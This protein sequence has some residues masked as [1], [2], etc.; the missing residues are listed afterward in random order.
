[1]NKNVLVCPLDWGIGHAT[2][3]VPVIKELIASGAHVFIAADNQPLAFLMKEFPDL[4]FVKF[5]G[6]NIYYPENGSMIIKM[7]LSLPKFLKE[8]KKENRLLAQIIA[9]KNI[10]V[11][12]SD[13]R[14][15]LWNKSVK[16]VFITHQLAIKCPKHFIFLEYLLFRINRRYI[17][18]YN[19]CWVPDFDTY[20]NLSGDLSHKRAKNRN[21][22]FIGPLSR[23]SVYK[24]KSANDVQENDIIAILS[25]PEP[26]RTIFENILTKQLLELPDLKA[27]IV[28]GKP[29]AEYSF[30]K[31]GN[32]E[33]YP[34]LDTKT[35][36]EKIYSAK[37]VICRSGY[38][39]I[40]DLAVIGAKAVLVPTPGQTEQE[41]LAKYF[42]NKNIFF[43]LSQKRF[44]IK[45]AIDN[46][47][48]YKGI[49]AR[50]DYSLL[51]TRIKN[52]IE[53]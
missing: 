48:F 36:L 23:F 39:S 51:N 49:E 28:R 20:I 15:G 38:S 10:D 16:T 31:N 11:V 47:I 2:R 35:L 40:M 9:D 21:T 33:I 8:I 45:T 41:Y 42:M 14:F 7:L 22:F 4:E 37:L 26:Q 44:R 50:N 1:M 13:N 34:H 24:S 25:G 19:E 3:C 29:D 52:L 27:I 53:S 32:I 18:R 17:N 5:P 43:A 30:K 6:F 46:A 12:I